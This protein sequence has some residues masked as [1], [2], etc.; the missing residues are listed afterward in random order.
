MGRWWRCGGGGAAACSLLTPFPLRY[1]IEGRALIS[2][3]LVVSS[4]LWSCASCADAGTRFA[5]PALVCMMVSTRR[6][7]GRV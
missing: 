7:N 1:S 6:A 2:I 5:L 3:E 4:A